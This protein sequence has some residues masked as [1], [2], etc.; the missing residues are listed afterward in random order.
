M[1]LEIF[2]FQNKFATFAFLSGCPC[3]LKDRITDSG[4]VGPGSIPSGG[5]EEGADFFLRLLFSSTILSR[6]WRKRCFCSSAVTI[7]S[8][9]CGELR[10]CSSVVTILSRI[11]GEL[12]FCSSVV[13]ILSRI[14]GKLCFCSSGQADGTGR[15]VLPGAGPGTRSV[16]GGGAAHELDEVAVGGSAAAEAGLEVERLLVLAGFPA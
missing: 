2:Q 10:F 5:T 12:R 6:I 4:S 15:F 13:T 9:I 3:S 16:V 11:C 7:L 1:S 8:R 14:C